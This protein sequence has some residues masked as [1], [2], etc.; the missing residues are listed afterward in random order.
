MAAN[1]IECQ[2]LVRLLDEQWMGSREG[3]NELWTSQGWRVCETCSVAWL[4][5]HRQRFRLKR[6]YN[7]SWS[8]PWWVMRRRVHKHFGSDDSG[9]RPR[10]LWCPSC[11]WSFYIFIFIKPSTQTKTSTRIYVYSLLIISYH[12]FKETIII[13]L[14]SF[15]VAHF[16]QWGI[17]PKIFL[18]TYTYVAVTCKTI[19]YCEFPFGRGSSMFR[20]T[21]AYSANWDSSAT[22]RKQLHSHKLIVQSPVITI[23]LPY[24]R[25]REIWNMQQT[26]GIDCN[27]HYHRLQTWLVWSF[28]VLS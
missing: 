26:A 23:I 3:C 22:E 18:G 21:A 2:V 19:N 13:F 15:Y 20:P 28:S 9:A 12:T 8:D 14:F 16:K 6:T 1:S 10:N 25:Q 11:H 7:S 17:P 24:R 27:H 4:T 5:S